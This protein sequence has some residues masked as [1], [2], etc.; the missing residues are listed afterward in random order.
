M[1]FPVDFSVASFTFTWVKKPLNLKK[2]T[3]P[4]IIDWCLCEKKEGLL[5][6]ILLPCC[7]HFYE[8]FIL[9]ERI[10]IKL[11]RNIILIPMELKEI[12]KV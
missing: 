11:C 12:S 10:Q 4:G 5:L 9:T 7:C 2:D 6:T 1:N 8:N 3:G